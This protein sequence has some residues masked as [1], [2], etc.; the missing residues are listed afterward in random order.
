MEEQRK[1]R[2]IDVRRRGKVRDEEAHEEE[3]EMTELQ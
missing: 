3:E 2:G 1:G